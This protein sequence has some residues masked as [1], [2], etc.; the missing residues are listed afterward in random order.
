[1]LT[2]RSVSIVPES[3]VD[4]GT[5]RIHLRATAEQ[6]L[7]DVLVWDLLPSSRAGASSRLPRLHKPQP[8]RLQLV[9]ADVRWPVVADV[10]HSFAQALVHL[11][12]CGTPSC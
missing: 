11:Q 8:Q 1:M 7:Q 6:L 9:S 3:Q 12:M 10:G 5:G 4:A 2:M